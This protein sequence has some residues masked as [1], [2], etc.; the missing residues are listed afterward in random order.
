MVLVEAVHSF[1]L[2]LETESTTFV[3]YITPGRHTVLLTELDRTDVR[4][5]TDGSI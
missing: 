4:Y 3:E 1:Q 2:I 5:D